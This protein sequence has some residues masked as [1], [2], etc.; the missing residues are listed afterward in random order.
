MRLGGQAMIIGDDLLATNSQ[1]L[2][3]A[4][5]LR[6]CNAILIKPNQVGTLTETLATMQLARSAGFKCIVSARS[7][8]TEDT[9]IA[10]LAV[11][12]AADYIKIGSVVR[13][14]RTA[15][16]NRLLRIADE[17]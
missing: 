13:G 15:K 6:A 8:E 12:T 1:R 16:Y 10:D 3:R 7:G 14:E 17:L 4:I 11:G 9:F 2:Q 5:E